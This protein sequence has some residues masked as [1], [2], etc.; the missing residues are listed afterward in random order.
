MALFALPATCRLRGGLI[1]FRKVH[2]ALVR[3]GAAP[4]PGGF[5]SVRPVSGARG[6][7][8][9]G[10]PILQAQILCHF[11]AF[12]MGLPMFL[13]RFEFFC[14]FPTIYGYTLLKSLY[15]FTASTVKYTPAGYLVQHH[16]QSGYTLSVQL[17]C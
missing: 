1:Q 11:R 4:V 8:T 12:F 7:S 17:D 13:Q 14:A 15:T 2:A 9:I 3:R 6:Y 10:K 16:I 5:R